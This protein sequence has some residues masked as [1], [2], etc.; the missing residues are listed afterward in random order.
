MIKFNCQQFDKYRL[1][2]YIQICPW[3]SG[4][5]KVKCL[6]LWLSST[7]Q[8]TNK[9]RARLKK[10]IIAYFSKLYNAKDSD[11]SLACLLL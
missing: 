3:Y 9:L 5:Y 7:I 6:R 10:L 4:S 11:N 2:H 8:E 1:I